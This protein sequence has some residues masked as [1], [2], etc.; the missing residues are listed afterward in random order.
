M[1]I[2]ILFIIF[3]VV[4][5]S[6]ALAALQS[7]IAFVKGGEVVVGT[8][9]R[10]A[11]TKDADG[12]YYYPVY[13]IPV[14]NG[15]IFTYRPTTST[16]SRSAWP[17]GKKVSFIYESGRPS[18]VKMLKYWRLYGWQLILLSVAINLILIG[19]GYFLLRGYFSV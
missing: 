15:E 8:I 12:T 3:G 7:R 19:V 13:E 14:G 9:V 6:F 11:E 17:V 4:M 18:D 5:L 16:S 2:Y 10:I 1:G